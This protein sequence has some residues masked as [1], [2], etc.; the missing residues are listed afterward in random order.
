MFRAFAKS[1]A[2][3][4]A[5][6]WIIGA[7]GDGGAESDQEANRTVYQIML[8]DREGRHSTS[9]DLFVVGKG[10]AR[11]AKTQPGIA[12]R[13]QARIDY[14]A[15]PLVG[16][17]S[18]HRYDKEDFTPEDEVGLVKVDGD[19]LIFLLNLT[20]A[21][22]PKEVKK[23][24][25]LNKSFAF[26]TER[27]LKAGRAVGHAGWD[28]RGRTVGILYWNGDGTLKALVRPFV[29]TDSGVW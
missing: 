24:V 2:I 17:L 5:A 4:A 22:K 12:R 16:H 7:G 21:P 23:L 26:E 19:R 18:E 8:E 10:Q 3:A 25:V 27:G 1:V 9:V 14:S 11:V 6:V 20:G 13:N 28:K 15:V 29:V